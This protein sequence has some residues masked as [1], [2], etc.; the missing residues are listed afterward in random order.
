MVGWSSSFYSQL[1][2]TFMTILKA[3]QAFWN[4]WS[5]LSATNTKRVS[6]Q[7]QETE[8]PEK[9][10]R[11]ERIAPIPQRIRQTK[12]IN[13]T[14][15]FGTVSPSVTRPPKTRSAQCY[16][17]TSHSSAPIPSFWCRLRNTNAPFFGQFF[18]GT[19]A[20]F[21]CTISPTCSNAL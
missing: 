17:T 9:R 14:K 21:A 2:L 13:C 3:S 18:S 16:T 15:N 5:I 20:S 6:E 1:R 8:T 19:K 11:F 10:V 4:D 12:M 7:A